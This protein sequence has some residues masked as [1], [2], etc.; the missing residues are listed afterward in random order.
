MDDDRQQ[1]VDMLLR[2]LNILWGIIEKEK[3]EGEGEEFKANLE[4]LNAEFTLCWRCL[5]LA[6]HEPVASVLGGFA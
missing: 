2:R 5:Q 4:S 1:Q 3:K 6:G